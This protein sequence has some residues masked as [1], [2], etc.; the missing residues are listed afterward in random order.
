[1]HVRIKWSKNEPN[2]G[3]CMWILSKTI[4][5][6]TVHLFGDKLFIWH[7]HKFYK[8]FFLFFP[9]IILSGRLHIWFEECILCM[10]FW[11]DLSKNHREDLVKECLEKG[12]E[13]VQAIANKLF[14]LP[15]TEDIDGPLVKLP[16]P[17]TRL[18][19]EKPVSSSFS[20][21]YISISI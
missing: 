20:F 19:R 8:A 16:P 21:F 3:M 1:M 11:I 17:T 5:S 12:T 18:P 6:F 15:S 7:F 10:C 13:L 14:N 4:P 9:N 2:P